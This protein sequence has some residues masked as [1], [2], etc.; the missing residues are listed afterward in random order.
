MQTTTSPAATAAP[1][2]TWDPLPSDY[3][4]PDDP[5]DNFSQPLLAAALRESLELAGLITPPQNAM[6]KSSP[7]C[8]ALKSWMGQPCDWAHLGN[9]TTCLWMVVALIQTG[10]VNLTRWIACIPCR[11]QYAQSKQRRV[12]RWLHNARINIHRLYKPLI[13]AALDGWQEA[14]LYLSLDT[15]LFWMN[16][17]WCDWP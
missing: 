1:K 6:N 3:G 17:A 9:L 16:T 2:V 7:L 15:S 12:Q 5:V 10:E 13:Q 14:T 8:N 4:L 11:G